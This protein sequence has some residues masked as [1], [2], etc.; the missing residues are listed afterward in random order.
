MPFISVIIMLAIGFGVGYGLL[1]IANTKEGELKS[2][3]KLLGWGLI[4]AAIIV[5]I[6]S[7][8]YSFKMSSTRYMPSGCPMGRMMEH[9]RTQMINSPDEQ[10][11]PDANDSEDNVN[12]QDNEQRPMMNDEGG[13]TTQRSEDKP[14]KN[15]IKDHE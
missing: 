7:F 13:R 1:V 8:I 5:A 4:A 12:L 14:A 9:Q 6:P 15:N 11:T 3:G 10:G 2:V